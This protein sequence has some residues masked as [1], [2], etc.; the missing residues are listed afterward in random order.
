MT[1][2]IPLRASVPVIPGLLALTHV[3][4]TGIAFS[5][6]TDVSPIIPA[7]ITLAVMVFVFSNRT[8]W[9]LTGTGRVA[10][11]LTGGGALGNLI[12]RVRVGAVIDY[13]DLQVWPV[14]NLADAAVTL[15][16]ALFVLALI[17]NNG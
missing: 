13:L 12:D 14:F 17:R 6:R 5:L 1:H 15:G 16:A 4:N 3:H 11:A 8:Q 2:F 9:A 10:L 7:L